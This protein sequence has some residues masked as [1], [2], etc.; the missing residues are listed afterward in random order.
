MC[1]LHVIVFNMGAVPTLPENQS[2][3]LVIIGG[4][5]AGAIALI[6]AALKTTPHFQIT[7][8]DPHAQIGL[9]RAYSTTDLRH[10]L[11]VPADKMSIFENHPLD[12]VDWL[13]RKPNQNFA[14]WPFVPRILF[15]EYL[16][17]KINALPEKS[18]KHIAAEAIALDALPNKKW[19]VT[20]TNGAK[21]TA[22]TVIVATGYQ[23]F[24]ERKLLCETD[25]KTKD[26]VLQPY[27]FSA[28]RKIKPQDR[29]IIVGTGLT[30]L[31][32][33]LHLQDLPATKLHFISRH[34][35]FPKPHDANPPQTKEILPT[36][37]GQSPLIIFKLA[38][39]ALRKNPTAWIALVNQIRDQVP[40]IW[41]NW[42]LPEKSQ[43]IRHISPFWEV[44]RH[45]VP[46]SVFKFLESLKSSGRVSV[47]AGRILRTEK[48]GNEIVVHYR[49]RGEVSTR[50]IHADWI[51]LATGAKIE[52]RIPLK[53]APGVF[54]LGPPAKEQFWETTA[55]PD[56]VKLAD[57]I[58]AK[59]K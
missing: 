12:F 32:V 38:L 46:I 19:Q 39:R 1:P 40:G 22:D 4:G 5:A 20:T 34:G 55:I 52:H 8:I 41:A 18:F 16:V 26:F 10:L 28:F 24:I 53:E 9:G 6:K 36:L 31:D 30:A 42:S 51:V 2:P 44:A 13:K 25:D 49:P 17:E 7:L 21:I 54:L 15:G 47:H 29:I 14:D 58:L 57:L 43:F 50:E 33:F 35:F 37:S 3:H 27:D 59:L 45:R 48:T 56:I 23:S 11:N